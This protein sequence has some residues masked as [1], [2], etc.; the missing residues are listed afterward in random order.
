L[1]LEHSS[2]AKLSRLGVK[3]VTDVDRAGFVKVATPFQDE[4]AKELGPNALKLLD[5]VRSVK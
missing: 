2:Q 5:L 3:F 1:G 4:Q